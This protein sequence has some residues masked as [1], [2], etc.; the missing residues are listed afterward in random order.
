MTFLSQGASTYLVGKQI[1][2]DQNGMRVGRAIA[3]ADNQTQLSGLETDFDSVPLIRN[4]IRG[5]ALSQHDERRTRR[6]RKSRPRFPRPPAS[7]STP[8]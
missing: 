4:L 1:V 7:A 3:Q 2:V 5:Y 8:K 6:G